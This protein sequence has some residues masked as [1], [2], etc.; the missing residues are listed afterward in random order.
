MSNHTV[1]NNDVDTQNVSSDSS[2]VTGCVKW[3]NNKAGYGFITVS[4]G[5]H[6][7]DVFVHHS[8]VNVGE[9]QYRFLVQGEY[10]EFDCVR[11]DNGPHQWQA[12][13]VT[14]PNSGRLMC[15]TRR[16]V[17]STRSSEGQ[18]QSSRPQYRQPREHH[19]SVTP[20][21]VQH[22]RRQQVSQGPRINR[23]MSPHTEEDGYEWL[24]VRRYPRGEQG[25]PPRGVR[26]QRVERSGQNPRRVRSVVHTP[27]TE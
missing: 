19:V 20:G 22:R 4:S 2:R 26:P 3:F 23:Q 10:V 17:R 12:S 18:E 27:D 11:V 1:T 15:E 13:N 14:G 6:A 25:Q 9:E 7:G 5:P 8:A 16:V 24:L 21:D